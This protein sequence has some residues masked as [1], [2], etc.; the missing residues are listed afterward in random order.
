MRPPDLSSVGGGRWRPS[1]RSSGPRALTEI[2]IYSGGASGASWAIGRELRSSERNPAFL[3]PAMTAGDRGGC[4]LLLRLDGVLRW[5][6][7]TLAME[8]GY[9]ERVSGASGGEFEVWVDF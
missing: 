4:L 7:G 2:G 6:A 3:G 5:V 8:F 1:G 9:L